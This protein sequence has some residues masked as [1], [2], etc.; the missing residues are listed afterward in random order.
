[1]SKF[2]TIEGVEGVGKS[3]QCQRLAN[4]I[5]AQYG[6]EVCL[7]REPG[8]TRLGEALRSILIDPEIPAM[9]QKSELLLMFAARA[10]HVETVI[11]PALADSS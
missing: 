9:H 8:G 3:T 6:C 1:M 2:I 10:E 7:T 4:W 11:K 5:S